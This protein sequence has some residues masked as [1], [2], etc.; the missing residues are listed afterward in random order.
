MQSL[1]APPFLNPQA[2]EEFDLLQKRLVSQ[3][4]PPAQD[5]GVAQCRGRRRPASALGIAH[6][7]WN[8]FH[9]Y[10]FM[11]VEQARPENASPGGS[12]ARK[13]RATCM[14]KLLSELG[15][16]GGGSIGTLGQ[17]L[18]LKQLFP[19]LKIVLPRLHPLQLA[20]APVFSDSVAS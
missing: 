1:T 19:A 7:T 5:Q 3:L 4:L 13:N 10:S 17:L 8:I 11:D 20:V 16:S 6:S 9:K 15:R 12:A 18:Q 2:D 14:F